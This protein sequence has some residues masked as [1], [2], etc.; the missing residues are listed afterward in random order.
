MVYTGTTNDMKRR[1]IPAIALK[2]SNYYG[3]YYF[4]SLYTGKCLH[5]YQWTEIPIDDDVITQVSDLPEG[6]NERKMTDNYPMFE[7]APGV[8]IT[9]YVSE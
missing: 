5:R 6:E 7:W 3:G 9:N 4:M 1:S 8:L 2:K